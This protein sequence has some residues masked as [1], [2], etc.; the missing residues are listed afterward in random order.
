M[1]ELGKGSFGSVYAYNKHIA[2]KE[3]PHDVMNNVSRYAISEIS[4]LYTLGGNFVPQ[5]TQ[6]SYD[7]RYTRIYIQRYE[8]DICK[9]RFTDS[10]MLK[11]AMFQIAMAVKNAHDNGIIHC[12]IN[13]RNILKLNYRYV[14]ADWGICHFVR[15]KHNPVKMLY[16][17]QTK[18]YRAP[19][20][21]LNRHFTK[22]SDIWSLAATYIFMI[23]Y[24]HIFDSPDNSEFDYGLL[25]GIYKIMGNNDKPNFPKFANVLKNNVPLEYYSLLRGM[26]KLNL[27]DRKNINWVIRHPIFRCFTISDIPKYIPIK[28]NIPRGIRL[29][30][31]RKIYSSMDIVIKNERLILYSIANNIKNL[32]V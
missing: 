18:F 11:Y 3:I 14:L 1:Q 10:Q 26:T 13:P 12:D 25:I 31:L 30:L 21:I 7:D 4:A 16:P 28:V 19:E 27:R 24:R 2:V 23:S 9:I 22:K 29:R 6:V 32:L 17:I 15:S 20:V 8:S 5:I